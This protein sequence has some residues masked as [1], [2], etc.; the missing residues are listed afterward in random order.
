MTIGTT[1]RT[2]SSTIVGVRYPKGTSR[3]ATRVAQ[4]IR[5]GRGG[6]F[7]CGEA[8]LVR[9]RV[10]IEDVGAGPAGNAGSGADCGAGLTDGLRDGLTDGPAVGCAGSI[11]HLLGRRGPHR[12]RQ[13]FAE[14]DCRP[15]PVH[16]AAPRLGGGRG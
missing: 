1:I 3:R 11:G 13:S 9:V 12:N 16:G 6:G 14:H 7:S 4:G 8:V 5:A 15:A 2:N 10:E